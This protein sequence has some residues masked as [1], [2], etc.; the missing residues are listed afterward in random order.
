MPAPAGSR[1][2]GRLL[3][4]MA[5]LL[6]LVF[7]GIAWLQAQSL[8]LL[9]ANVVY[10]GDNIVWSFF[11]LE[12]EYLRLGQQLR[13]FARDGAALPSPQRDLAE[14][15]LRERYD[16]FVSRISLVDPQRTREVMPDL[17]NVVLSARHLLGLIGGILDLSRIEAGRMDL[18]QEGFDIV[19]SIGTSS[20]FPYIVQPVVYA[21]S[22]GIPTVEI[23][24][25]RTQLTDIVDY[26]LPLGA[27]EAM[28]RILG[29][30]GMDV[31]EN[32]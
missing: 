31:P 18:V 27:A 16:I 5:L 17:K 23:N 20:V 4:V 14:T 13:D 9:S 15:D 2:V 3:A 12:T 21:A 6:A 10:Q 1:R 24:P 22:A 30:L 25:A 28:T 26:Y 19:F 32:V 7:G 8:R 29:E 11:Q